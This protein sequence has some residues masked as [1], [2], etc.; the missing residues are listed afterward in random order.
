MSAPAG[1]DAAFML[2]ALSLAARNLGDTWPNPSVGCLIVNDGIVVGRGW[3]QSGGR[4]HAETEAL[5][6]AGTAAKGATAYVTLEPCSHHGKTPPCADALIAA[7]IARAVIATGDP[8]PR[9]SGQGVAKLRAAGIAV[10]QGLRKAEADRLNAGFFLRVSHNRPLFAL[11]TATSLDG[12]I[13]LANGDSKWITGPVAR[14]AVQALRARFDAILVGSGT[15]LADDPMLNCRLEGYSGRPKVRIIL[16][17]RLRLPLTSRLVETAHAIPT[18]IV[19]KDVGP[20]AEEFAARGLEIIAA[21]DIAAVLAARG[22]TRVLVEGGGEV[23]AS[24]LK[25]GIIDEIAWFRAGRVIG[26]EGVPAVGP[27]AAAYLTATPG[28]KRRETLVFGE[29][30]LDILDRA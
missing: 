8:D 11:K 27:V 4:P 9:V 10:E 1:A 20:K 15:A 5:A 26:S 22:I 19:T 3:T 12:R 6:R 17:R 28:F 25:A 2:A 16:D 29:D 21:D 30:S 7:G 14:Q 18:W 13:A 23:A 24:F